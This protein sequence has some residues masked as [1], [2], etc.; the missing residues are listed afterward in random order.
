MIKVFRKLNSL[1]ESF[2][3]NKKSLEQ[4]ADRYFRLFEEH[5]VS[6]AQI[7]RLIPELTLAD[8]QSPDSL[9]RAL[10]PQIIDKTAALFA[11]RPQ[12]LEGVDDVIYQTEFCYQALHEFF[13]KLVTLKNDQGIEPVRVFAT[14]KQLDPGKESKL[15]LVLVER[16]AQLEEYGEQDIYRYHLFSDSW[17]WAY[18]KARI[19]LKAI[20][21]LVVTRFRNRTGTVPIFTIDKSLIENL[22]HGRIFPEKL[23]KG[24]WVTDPSLEDYVMTSEESAV[25]KD[26]EELSR[27]LQYIDEHRLNQFVDSLPGES[28]HDLELAASGVHS[29]EHGSIDL[30]DPDIKRKILSENNKAIAK[31][32]Y[33]EADRLKAE[34]KEFYQLNGDKYKFKTDAMRAYFD[35]LDVK[36]RKVLVPSYYEK[37]HQEFYDN[38][39]RNLREVLKT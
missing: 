16:I 14:D 30:K 20:T 32:K 8:V 21:R 28:Q 36:N 11:I 3:D 9:L 17:D 31:A 34:F 6:R 2:A 37:A 12:W 23:F 22:W 33:A 25:A 39:I 27:V 29:E 18:P 1:F 35:F 10:T 5:N 7:P 19:Q 13:R 4:V 24:P 26:V 15:A 38:A